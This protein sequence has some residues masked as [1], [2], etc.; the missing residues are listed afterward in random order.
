MV[1]VTHLSVHLCAS[2]EMKPP[3]YSIGSIAIGVTM[4]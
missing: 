2:D 1:S 4:E 3:I